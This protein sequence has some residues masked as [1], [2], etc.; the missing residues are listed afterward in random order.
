MSFLSSLSPRSAF[1]KATSAGISS[2]NT[3]RPAVVE[4]TCP[5]KGALS[6]GTLISACQSILFDSAA[7]KASFTELNRFPVPLALGL[8]FVR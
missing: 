6:T 1:S 4:I 7:S 8:I 2:L 3:R 5:L